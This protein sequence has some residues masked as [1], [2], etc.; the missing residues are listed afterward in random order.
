MHFAKYRMTVDADGETDFQIGSRPGLANL[1]WKPV[2]KALEDD[3]WNLALP[4][5]VINFYD[6]QVKYTYY[7]TRIDPLMTLLAIY[8]TKVR[9][10]CPKL[11]K[12][13][14]DLARN[15]RGCKHFA[16]LKAQIQAR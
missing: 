9:G 10:K 7:M 15:L 1:H 11:T 3:R 6:Q 13:M 4:N 12:F 2:L 16:A 8:E 14:L 5:T